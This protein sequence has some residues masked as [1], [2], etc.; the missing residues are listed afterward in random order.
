MASRITVGTPGIPP[1]YVQT[2]RWDLIRIPPR[3]L[4]LIPYLPL[5]PPGNYFCHRTVYGT[6][7]LE[8]DLHHKRRGR[9]ALDERYAQ[10]PTWVSSK[11]C[12]VSSEQGTESTAGRK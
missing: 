1:L 11:E 8:A 3:P 2:I 4:T 9:G 10:D 6:V 5:T 12:T 7:R